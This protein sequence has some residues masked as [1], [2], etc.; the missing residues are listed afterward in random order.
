MPRLV[1]GR[2]RK[3][4]E[5]QG[6]GAGDSRTQRR[7]FPGKCRVTG[8]VQMCRVCAVGW[9]FLLRD[10]ERRRVQMPVHAVQAARV[11]TVY[12]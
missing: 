7:W 1:A 12:V 2:H 11:I 4:G 10:G 6:L 8:G 9:G 3:A 5:V